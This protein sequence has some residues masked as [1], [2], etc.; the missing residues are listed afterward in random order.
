MNT[1]ITFKGYNDGS[2]KYEFPVD[3]KNYTIFQDKAGQLSINPNLKGAAQNEAEKALGILKKALE[4]L[5]QESQPKFQTVSTPSKPVHSVFD[6]AYSRINQVGRLDKDT[7]KALEESIDSY[8]KGVHEYVVAPSEG[9]EKIKTLQ[10]KLNA[11]SKKRK[12][13]V[14][15]R[16]SCIGRFFHKLAQFFTGGGFRTLAERTDALSNKIR[17]LKPLLKKTVVRFERDLIKWELKAIAKDP[18]VFDKK[19]TFEKINQLSE[20]EFKEIV[21]IYF[22][23]TEFISCNE[24]YQN[25]NTEKR[26]LFDDLILAQPD[27]YLFIGSHFYQHEMNGAESKKIFEL[28]GVNRERYF[29]QF[30]TEFEQIAQKEKEGF[31]FSLG[32][33]RNHSIFDRSFKIRLPSYVSNSFL[34]EMFKEAVIKYVNE[35]NFDRVLALL[36]ALYLKEGTYWKDGIFFNVDQEAA[37]ERSKKTLNEVFG[38][39]PETV[40]QKLKDNINCEHYSLFTKEVEPNWG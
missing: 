14:E 29:N 17:G 23:S 36:D 24:L 40:V 32:M 5:R 1:T 3:G 22:S 18:K 10:G 4:Q 34:K 15:N 11:L 16:F 7:L 25:L 28:P 38:T 2:G 13:E 8:V 31:A 26:A 9:L 35:E 30:M 33:Q 27:W 6:P 19:E 37:E 20:S 21:S 12:E 39:L